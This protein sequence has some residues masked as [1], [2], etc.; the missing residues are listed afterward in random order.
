MKGKIHCLWEWFPNPAHLYIVGEKGP[1][2]QKKKQLMERN[3]QDHLLTQVHKWSNEIKTVYWENGRD[4]RINKSFRSHHN[5]SVHTPGGQWPMQWDKE[6]K[7][8]SSCPLRKSLAILAKK[9]ENLG[10]MHVHRS[11]YSHL[12]YSSEDLNLKLATV[13]FVGSP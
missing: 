6:N 10:T 8:D 4:P 12:L 11:I 13:L 1:E 7:C 5:V 2:P 9:Q 3:S